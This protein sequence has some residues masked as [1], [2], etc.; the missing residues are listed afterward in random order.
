M[1]SGYC[2]EVAPITP[3][4]TE[5]TPGQPPS[6]ETIRTWSSKADRLKRL[7]GADGG[8]FVD[9]VDDVDA[10]I[11]LEEVLHRGAAAFFVA[12]GDVV[13]DDARVILVADVVG[14]LHVDP[15]AHHEALVA[16]DV[17]G[18]LGRR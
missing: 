6:T 9:R 15:E 18:R 10:G 8:G 12:V 14:V 1:R 3:S 2:C 5:A 13:A 16:Q 7:V 4:L 11:A 17:H